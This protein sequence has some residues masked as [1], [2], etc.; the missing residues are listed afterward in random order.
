MQNVSEWAC[1]CANKIYFWKRQQADV[2]PQA[3]ICQPLLSVIRDTAL[4]NTSLLLGLLQQQLVLILFHLYPCLLFSSEQPRWFCPVSSHAT[5]HRSPV[6]TVIYRALSAPHHFLSELISYRSSLLLVP[7]SPTGHGLLLEHV[8]Q[9][10]ISGPLHLRSPLPG[11][12]FSRRY[13]SQF[14]QS[15]LDIIPKSFFEVSSFLAIQSEVSYSRY[16]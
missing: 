2:D 9:V 6:F 10:D 14:L 5:Q 13:H 11:I 4:D 3:I 16:F 1:L 8:K 7:T 12:L 15:C